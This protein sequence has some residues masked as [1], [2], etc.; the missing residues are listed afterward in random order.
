MG[1]SRMIND[2]FWGDPDFEIST[3]SKMTLAMLLTIRETNIIGVYKANWKEVAARVGWTIEQIMIVLKTLEEAGQIEFFGNHVWVKSWWYHNSL[4]HALSP[5]MRGATEKEIGSLPAEYQKKVREWMKIKTDDTVL[6]PCEYSID[7]VSPTTTDT[8]TDTDTDTTTTNTNT[9]TTD[10]NSDSTKIANK[11]SSSCDSIQIPT[12]L[13]KFREQIL[14]KV[15]CLE[16]FLGQ[17]VID[18]LSAGLADSSIKSPIGWLSN[19]VKKAQAGE[20]VPSK[21]LKIEENER[22]EKE[23]KKNA[24]AAK[25]AHKAELDSA[26]PSNTSYGTFKEAAQKQQE[27]S[28]YMSPYR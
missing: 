26:V 7:A 3:E 20:F 12:N 22:R 4:A 25:A 5:K 9:N 1:R 15:S 19:V 6:I 24:A 21:S 27:E 10:S 13:L 2:E 16:P 8:T 11:G 17:K 28:K 18:E 14:I 23:R